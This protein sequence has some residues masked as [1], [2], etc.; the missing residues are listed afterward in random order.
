MGVRHSLHL[1]MVSD[2]NEFIDCDAPTGCGDDLM[3]TS[4]DW[5]V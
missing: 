5:R 1:R 4:D 3:I 2:E